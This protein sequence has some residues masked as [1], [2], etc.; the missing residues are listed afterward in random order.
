MKSNEKLRIGEL[1]IASDLFGF[2]IQGSFQKLEL[3]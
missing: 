1:T 3:D 2:G